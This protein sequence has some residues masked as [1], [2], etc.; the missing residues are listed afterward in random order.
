MFVIIGEQCINLDR[1]NVIKPVELEGGHMGTEFVFDTYSVL[2]DI[3][4]EDVV[5]TV[6]TKRKR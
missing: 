2:C 5:G 3:L 1:V 6:T 4:Y